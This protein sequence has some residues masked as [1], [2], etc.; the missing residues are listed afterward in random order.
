MIGE[1]NVKWGIMLPKSELNTG[2]TSQQGVST[3]TSW[4]NGGDGQPQSH[5]NY[6]CSIYK[7]ILSRKVKIEDKG[8]SANL[9]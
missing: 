2:R 4:S 8:P 1:M 9:I 3:W 6:I 5:S 7:D